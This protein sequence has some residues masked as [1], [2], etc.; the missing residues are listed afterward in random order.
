MDVKNYLRPRPSF[1]YDSHARTHAR[2]F[3]AVVPPQD[4]KFQDEGQ[5]G[6]VA[7]VVIIMLMSPWAS[8]FVA[9]GTKSR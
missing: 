2:Y 5:K 4:V 7:Y 1:I 6:Y 9:D 3:Y 8:F